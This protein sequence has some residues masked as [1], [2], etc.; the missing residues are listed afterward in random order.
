MEY[1]L[2]CQKS[3]NFGTSLPDGMKNFQILLCIK[4]VGSLINKSDSRIVLGDVVYVESKK[5]TS[6][7]IFKVN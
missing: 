1:A 3:V 4:S 5:L 6:G 7:D 2:I